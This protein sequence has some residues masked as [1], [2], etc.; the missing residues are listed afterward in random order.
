MRVYA[1]RERRKP[2]M[3]LV[4]IATVCIAHGKY[5]YLQPDAAAVEMWV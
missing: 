3:Y 5:V 4:S 1:A 2:S